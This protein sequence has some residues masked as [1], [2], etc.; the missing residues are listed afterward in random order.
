MIEA[1]GNV[2]PRRIASAR[3]HVDALARQLVAIGP[4]N[5]LERG[6]TY[7]LNDKGGIVRSAGDVHGGDRVT[8]VLTD[9]RFDS[10]VETSGRAAPRREVRG[11]KRPA[12]D[13]P[14]LFDLS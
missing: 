2:L 7:T 5:V 3:Q 9:G 1:L 4:A 13:E 8:T 11:R 14:D 12:T 6:Y 10:R